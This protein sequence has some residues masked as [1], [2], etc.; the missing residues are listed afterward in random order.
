MNKSKS[1]R[2][3]SPIKLEGMS[4]K[5][6]KQIKKE[7]KK[8]LLTEEVRNL[9][10]KLE[11]LQKN[12]SSRSST[13]SSSSGSSTSSDS[14]SRRPTPAKRERSEP[15]LI[16]TISRGSSVP[17]PTCS[18]R[19]IYF[20]MGRGKKIGIGNPPLGASKNKLFSSSAGDVK[21]VEDITKKM[22]IKSQVPSAAP[23]LSTVPEA[24]GPSGAELATPAQ[25]VTTSRK[26]LLVLS[27]YLFPKEKL[28]DMMR[29]AEKF[30]GQLNR[31]VVYEGLYRTLNKLSN[32]VE[33]M[34]KELLRLLTQRL[35]PNGL[36]KLEQVAR[37]RLAKVIGEF[38]S[39]TDRG[40]QAIR[41]RKGTLPVGEKSPYNR[42][43]IVLIKGMTGLQEIKVE[44]LKS[45]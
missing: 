26:V 18:K 42:A 45:S 23:A 7:L 19:T 36:R 30:L 16:S 2:S 17:E 21:S 10:G 34:N 6:L 4:S 8:K 24:A 32:D 40:T 38:K 5:D 31:T 9:Q 12:S 33:E 22:S 44:D 37:L 25:Q 27:P 28:Q 14:K 11:K 3:R 1:Q 29:E 20:G 41:N 35:R 13:S 43:V 39:V 15:S